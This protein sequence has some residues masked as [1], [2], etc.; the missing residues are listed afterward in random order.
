MK[1]YIK[2]EMTDKEYELK[3]ANGKVVTW[4]GKDGIDAATRYADCNHG[5]VV[6]AWREPKCQIRIYAGEPI[7]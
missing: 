4:T 1:V 5:A 2:R 3:L 7:I 6:V